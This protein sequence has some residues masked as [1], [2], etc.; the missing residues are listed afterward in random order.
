VKK[1]YLS[2]E[3]SREVPNK[4]EVVKIKTDDGKKETLQKHVMT[5]TLDDAF[6]HF[7]SLNPDIK[8]GFT[9]FRKIKPE[10]VRKISET[11]RRSCLCQVCCNVALKVD[12]LKNHTKTIKTPA[13]TE[14]LT[15][16]EL[17]KDR[18]S[19]ETMCPYQDLPNAQCLNRTCNDCG[20][21][22]MTEYLKPIIDECQDEKVTWF[23]WESTEINKDN[24]IKR[25]VSC[26]PKEHS[27]PEFLTEMKKDLE[28]YPGHIFRA[29]WQQKQMTNCIKNLKPGSVA[30]VMDFSENYGCVF[31]SE[32]QSGFFDRN[33]VTVHPMMAYYKVIEEGEEERTVKHAI[34]GISEDNKHDADAVVEFENKALEI[35]SKEIDITEVHEWTDGCAAQYK[36]KK[37]FADI[38]LRRGTKIYRNY[39]ETSHGKNVC[40][41]LGAIVKNSCYQAVISSRKVIGN[42]QDVYDHCEQKLTTVKADEDERTISKRQFILVSGIKRDRPETQVDTMKGTRKI[43]AVRNTGH[44]YK[45]QTRKLSCY[46]LNC[47]DNSGECNHVDYCHE[48]EDQTLKLTKEALQNTSRDV[49]TQL[50]VNKEP[51][52]E[53]MDRSHND[54]DDDAE[55]EQIEDGDQGTDGTKN[56]QEGM[57]VAITFTSK[58]RNTITVCIGQ[59][60]DI[61]GDE[62][63]VK[64]MKKKGQ[65]YIWPEKEEVFWELRSKVVNQLSEPTMDQ[66]AHYEFKATELD[67]VSK[68]VSKNFKFVYFQ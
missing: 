34:I 26:V 36:G 18:L 53:Q 29:K 6:K 4:R 67:S 2:A 39:F 20:T 54:D 21:Q 49:A 19:N 23:K 15:S 17:N 16:I 11:S 32:V 38:S 44:D 45:L 47:S 66:R 7:K 51:T 57:F 58:R 27:F 60:L 48:W 14:Q 25:C 61:D 13:N 24:K 30:M 63:Q 35:V 40:D 28:L 9:M 59:V 12:A 55:T 31:Q 46:C 5:M 65:K 37:S 8:I 68:E 10:N 56:L 3:V 50:Q 43:H 41:G 52:T 62:F 42:A 1:Y 33:Q 22:K 64:Y